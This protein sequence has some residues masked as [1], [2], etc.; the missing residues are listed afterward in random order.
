ME[1]VEQP[2]E[3]PW[4]RRTPRPTQGLLV[5]LTLALQ[6]IV[7]LR[8]LVWLLTLNGLLAWSGPHA[9]APTVSWWVVGAGW[10]VL[11]SPFGRMGLAAAGARLLLRGVG[12]GR[13]PRG[14]RV[15]VRLW[16][17]EQL[18][19]AAGAVTLAGAPWIA[20]YARALG[21]T[22]G[23]GVDLHTLP[24]VT[25][26]LTVGD[27]ASIEPEVDLA[28]WWLDGDE[29]IL[30]RVTIGADATVG[31]A[32]HVAPGRSHRPRRRGGSGVGGGGSRPEG[33][34]VVRLAG[35]AQGQGQGAVARRAPTASMA[36]GRR[37][38]GQLVRHVVPAARRG[39]GRCRGGRRRGAG[40]G[41]AA[42]GGHP[43]APRRA[44]RHRWWGSAPSPS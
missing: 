32:E 31:V 5:L 8:W 6:T 40:H 20:Y 34:A 44:A 28:G 11:V 38:R 35:R 10:V 41:D 19:G 15:H 13:Y 36:V 4:V 24:P 39:A 30:G 12:P 2:E 7:G 18:A 33:R 25:G 26:L 14:G 43:G 37:V 3:R 23:K 27:G 29:V 21:A 17:A 1:A 22:I 9:W 16:A 42:R